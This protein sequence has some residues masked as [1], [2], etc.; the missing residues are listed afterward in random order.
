MTK[1]EQQRLDKQLEGIAE[2]LLL[3]GY[4]ETQEIT[5]DYYLHLLEIMRDSCDR[6]ISYIKEQKMK[7]NKG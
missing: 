5:S 4:V 7:R 2:N 3:R 1:K 6:R